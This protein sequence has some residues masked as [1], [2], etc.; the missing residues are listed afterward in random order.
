[1]NRHSTKECYFNLKNKENNIKNQH[2]NSKGRQNQQQEK[3]SLNYLVNSRNYNNY[4][5]NSTPKYTK[6][7]IYSDNASNYDENFVLRMLAH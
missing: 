7:E 1:M 4:R 6:N 5:N 2:N 3:K